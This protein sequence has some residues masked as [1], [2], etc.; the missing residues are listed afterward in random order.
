MERSKDL[1]HF[2]IHGRANDLYRNVT[3]EYNKKKSKDGCAGDDVVGF[4]EA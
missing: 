3:P 4:Y 1:T 2:E